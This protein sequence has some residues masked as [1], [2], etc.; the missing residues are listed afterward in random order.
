MELKASVMPLPQIL[1]LLK[2]LSRTRFG[3]EYPSEAQG[4]VVGTP[5]S[6]ILVTLSKPVPIGR[7]L[8][9]SH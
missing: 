1:L 7:Q 5:G 9:I 4:E 3:K 6:F 2:S 8:V